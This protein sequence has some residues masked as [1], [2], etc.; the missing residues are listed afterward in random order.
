MFSLLL[1]SSHHPLLIYPHSFRAICKACK[2]EV[3]FIF[4][5]P[6]H[7]LHIFI[8]CWFW[9]HNATSKPR[10][11]DWVRRNVRALRELVVMLEWER[12]GLTLRVRVSFHVFNM[13]CKSFF[14]IP[15]FFMASRERTHCEGKV[16]LDL[17]ILICKS[18]NSI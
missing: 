16:Y 11:C 1:Y 4:Y 3:I 5:L 12:K 10:L 9:L 15:T 7:I 6:L 2:K 14:S 17:W 13:I 18:F 8:F